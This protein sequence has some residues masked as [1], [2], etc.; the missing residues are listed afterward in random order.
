[1]VKRLIL[2]AVVL[3]TVT[4]AQA[5]VTVHF[6]RNPTWGI[7]NTGDMAIAEAQI[8]AE[9]SALGGTQ[10]LFEFHNDGAGTCVVESIYF[11]DGG[12]IA[13]GSLIDRD[14]IGGDLH[15]DFEP[16]ATPGNPPGWTG[17]S[18]SFFATD[19]DSP[20]PT[21]GINNGTPTGDTLGIVFN[22]L[23]GQKLADVETALED[24]N[25]EIA[26]HVVAFESGGSEWLANNGYIPAPGAI[27][28]GG[29]G[30]GLVGWL[31]RRRML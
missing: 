14:V 17:T 4:A 26:M 20:A 24:H 12:L 5:N 11:R 21:W 29:I 10:V 1:M 31:R 30:V 28:L 3:A 16:G 9:V 2:I 15:V 6:V 18:A 27:L 8:F 7:N 19:A 22:L 13:F 23:G 25:L